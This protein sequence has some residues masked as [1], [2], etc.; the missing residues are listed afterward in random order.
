MASVIIVHFDPSKLKVRCK[1][2]LKALFLHLNVFSVLPSFFV[3]T[4]KIFSV[5]RVSSGL[6]PRCTSILGKN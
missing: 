2:S 1:N 3:L 4:F 5:I 6:L